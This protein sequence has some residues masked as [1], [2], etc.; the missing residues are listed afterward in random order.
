MH[1][2][3]NSECFWSMLGEPVALRKPVSSLINGIMLVWYCCCYSFITAVNNNITSISL[4]SYRFLFKQLEMA[5]TVPPMMAIYIILQNYNIVI[6]Q[7]YKIGKMPILVH[8]KN[9]YLGTSKRKVYLL[10]TGHMELIAHPPKY[11]SDWNS[12][13]T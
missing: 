12:R 13:K 10:I 3:G 2:K 11:Y 4:Y 7:Y 1:Q 6:L 5:V 8:S 9:P